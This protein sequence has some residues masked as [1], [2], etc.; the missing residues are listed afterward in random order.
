MVCLASSYKCEGRCY[1]GK[2]LLGDQ[3]GGWLRPVSTS[4]T[5][6]I[7]L[8]QCRYSDGSLPKLLDIIEIPVLRPAARHH[9]TE[10]HLIDAGPWTKLGE[11]DRRALSHLQDH[12]AT[13][14]LNTDHTQK[15]CNDCV[16]KAEALSFTN[17]LAFI[18]PA[19]LD[20]EVLSRPWKNRKTCRATF[21]Y[22]RARY[23][24]P[25]TDPAVIDAFS[26][27]GD[28]TYPLTRASLCVSLTEP[29]ELDGRC[30]KLVASVIEHE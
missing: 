9:Q 22:N 15:G 28:G 5:A 14:W 13:L 10:N 26:V 11:F 25:L 6:E 30:H 4:R 8:E 16:S 2:E 20:I 23:N 21:H 24:L 27:K 1:A 18:T 12:P 7:S 19:H 17:S 3:I 29:Y